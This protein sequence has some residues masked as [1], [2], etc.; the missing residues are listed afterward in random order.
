MWIVPKRANLHQSICFIEAIIDKGYN[1]T[2]WTSLKQDNI[3]NELRKRGATRTGRTPSPQAMRTHLSLV[4]YLGFIYIDDSTTPNILKVTE[5]GELFL[6]YH[7]NEIITVENLIEGKRN[8]DLILTSPIFRNQ[9]EKL[10]LTNP[11]ELRYCENIFL[12]PFRVAIKLINDLGYLD[13]EEIGYLLLMIKDEDEIELTKMKIIRFR[14]QTKSERLEEITA[15][16]KTRKGN[17]AL[18]QAPAA[19]Y[20]INLC[21]NTGIISKKLHTIP[22][23]GPEAN[24]KIS[25]IEIKTEAI[26]I[27]EE[28]LNR[29]YLGAIP[30]DFSTNKKL[31]ME[32]FGKPSRLLPPVDVNVTND[33]EDEIIIIIEKDNLMISGDLVEAS[34][35][36]TFPMFLNESYELIMIDP[37]TGTH[38]NKETITP[39]LSRKDFVV[40]A[41]IEY[42]QRDNIN[43]LSK[44]IIEHSE[45]STF[46]K[47]YLM[48][49][50]V[51]QG[52]TA[53]DYI[54]NKNLRGGHFEYLFFKL[55]EELRKLNVVDEVF[56]NGSIGEFGLPRPAPGGKTG[57]PDI[58]FK[59]NNINFIL[60]VTTIKSKSTQFS[61]EASSVPDHIRLFE[62]EN[63]N[64]KVYGIYSAPLIYS[65]N[66][67]VMK[68]VLDA[69]DI[70]LHCLET[71]LLIDLLASQD[72]DKIFNDLTMN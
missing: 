5:A 70:T 47:E 39:D 4:Q 2:R 40:T 66:T 7:Q 20:F 22:N 67:A 55:L 42:I 44:R 61:A 8:N 24:K 43:S 1:N 46:D 25:A 19:G 72:R 31:W 35:V 11:N 21:I 6:N 34:D 10:Q 28:I 13:Q 65:R 58:V 68:A 62:S 64:E 56:W 26:D 17:I 23:P 54:N 36:I 32:Y 51:L 69:H 38:L 16:K 53:K 3:G 63:S 71:S 37:L 41:P 60:E 49:L 48:Y 27:V 33:S 14:E 50:E 45:S 59:I 29:K 12:F 18:V 52:I 15:F 30:Y 9:F 57:T